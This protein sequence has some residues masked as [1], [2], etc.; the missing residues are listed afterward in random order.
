MPLPAHIAIIPDGNRRWAKK[1]GLLSSLGHKSGID[2]AENLFRAAQTHGIKYLTFW[3]CSVSNVTKRKNAEVAF[4]F[5]L[6][7]KY[8]DRLLQSDEA[9]RAGVRVRVFGEWPDY[10]PTKLQKTI[11]ALVTKTEP[12]S[13]FHLTFLLAYSGLIEL[14]H[15]VQALIAEK[16]AASSLPTI[17]PSDIKRHLYTKDLPPVDLLI[18]TGV[19]GDPHLSE[20]FMMWDTANAQLCLTDKLFPDFTPDELAKAINH[21]NKTERRL[22]G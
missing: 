3:G 11:S 4:L 10:L 16:T 17:A 9:E 21:Y 5:N 20:G 19:E 1:R 2:M 6:F 22:G 7:Q 18:R 14:T 13:K 12:N 8:F 15:A